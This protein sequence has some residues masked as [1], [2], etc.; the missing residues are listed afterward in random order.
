VRNS[1]WCFRRHKWQSVGQV[2]SLPRGSYSVCTE[3]ERCGVS[4][5]RVGKS[6]AKV[7]FEAERLVN[8]G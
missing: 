3:C 6:R 7:A 4:G 5:V 1:F 8:H 2:F